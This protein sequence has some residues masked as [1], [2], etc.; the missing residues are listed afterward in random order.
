MMDDMSVDFF[1]LSVFRNSKNISKWSLLFKQT[2]GLST[3]SQDSLIPCIL[4]SR[5]AF[6]FS[7]LALSSFAMASMKA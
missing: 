7:S 3:T 6:I 4:A 2:R 5:T 1:E